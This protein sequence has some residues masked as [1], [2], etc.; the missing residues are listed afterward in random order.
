MNQ[1][2]DVP[3]GGGTDTLVVQAITDNTHI[4]VWNAPT[5]SASGQTATCNPMCFAIPAGLGGVYNISGEDGWRGGGGTVRE[6]N[7]VV[8]IPTGATLA[9]SDVRLQ[10]FYASVA[11]PQETS[12]SWTCPIE[13]QEGDFVSNWVYHDAGATLSQTP[14]YIFTMSLLGVI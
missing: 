3:G 5:H 8:N 6:S 2:I 11:S 14:L 4:D 9:A 12:Y 13:L 10:S 1:V 7:L